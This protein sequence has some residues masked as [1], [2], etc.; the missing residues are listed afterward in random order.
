MAAAQSPSR[1]KPVKSKNST[2]TKIFWII[3]HIKFDPILV[4]LTSLWIYLEDVSAVILI[5]TCFSTVN[6]LPQNNGLLG[7]LSFWLKFLGIYFITIIYCN[8][9]LYSHSMSIQKVFKIPWYAN[10]IIQCQAEN[11]RSNCTM[12]F[13]ACTTYLCKGCNVILLFHLLLIVNLEANIVGWILDFLTNRSQRV[14]VTSLTWHSHKLAHRRRVCA[15]PPFLHSIHQWLSLCD[16]CLA[17]CEVCWWNRY[18]RTQGLV[19]DRFIT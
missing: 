9:I 2:I 11:W 18:Y 16:W 14:R 13:V 1:Q 15:L 10:T 6:K 17:H 7:K 19:I 4:A 12:S 8:I 3:N 5:F